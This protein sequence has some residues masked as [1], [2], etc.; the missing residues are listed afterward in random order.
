MCIISVCPKGTKKHTEEVN[1]FIRKGASSNTQG[2]GFM[3]KRNGESVIH[4][5]KGFFNVEKLI[6]V[7]KSYNLAD[8]DELVIHHRIST[9]GKVNDLNCHPFVISQIHEEVILTHGISDKSCLAH[10]GVFSSI[11]ELEELDKD[12]S[13][14]YAFARHLMSNP[15]VIELFNSNRTLFNI[16]TKDIISHNKLAI[17]SPDKDL[18]LIGR[19]EEENGYKH[20]NG[21]YKSYVYDKGG[22]SGYT[23][24][25]FQEE[26]EALFPDD[27]RLQESEDYA[28][29]GSFNLPSRQQLGLHSTNAVENL[30][31]KLVRPLAFTGT[32]LL[33]TKENCTQFEFMSAKKYNT[34]HPTSISVLPRYTL[35][36]YL[37]N[38]TT[39]I[40]RLDTGRNIERLYTPTIDLFLDYV[41]LPK[42]KYY[43]IYKGFRDL[44]NANIKH[45]KSS[46]KTLHTAIVNSYKKKPEDIVRYKTVDSLFPKQS[47]VLYE[48][49]LLRQGITTQNKNRLMIV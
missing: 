40:L 32:E 30:N 36:E 41:M 7:L 17:L 37:P 21:G 12:F 39:Q 23:S 19:F 33:L 45:S 29:S 10:N 43:S 44:L 28:I 8:A 26:I 1:K 48:A 14:T 34:Y 24:N 2:S 25:T 5:E 6:E 4:I 47:L 13:D 20:S 46:M 22:S 18:I 3:F 49:Y 35:E 11:K 16:L 31:S 27:D 38:L 9:S 15:Q 42:I